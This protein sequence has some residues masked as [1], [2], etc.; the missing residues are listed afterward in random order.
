VLQELHDLLEAGAVDLDD[1]YVLGAFVVIVV[2]AGLG[3][4][5]RLGEAGGGVGPVV[6]LEA[7]TG[8]KWLANG[9]SQ[10]ENFTATSMAK[11]RRR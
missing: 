3:V 11:V 6:G 7:M 1:L 10:D 9:E 8:D 2:L 4:L 5:Y